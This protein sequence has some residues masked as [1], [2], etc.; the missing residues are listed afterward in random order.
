MIIANIWPESCHLE[1]TISTLRFASRM[2]MVT[3]SIT[4]RVRLDPEAL[5]RKYERMIKDLK[6]E[7]AMHDTLVGR[8]R[9][10]YDPYSPE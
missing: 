5:L 3:N 8:G 10:R 4:Q 9:I 7:L 6:T 1:E 2:T